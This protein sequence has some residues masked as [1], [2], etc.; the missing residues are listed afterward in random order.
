ML[1][2]KMSKNTHKNTHKWILQKTLNP[3][4]LATTDGRGRIQPLLMRV[5]VPLSAHDISDLAP[6]STHTNT[7]I[8]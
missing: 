5:R 8:H 4:S 6:K 2:C 3:Q 1:S 7:H